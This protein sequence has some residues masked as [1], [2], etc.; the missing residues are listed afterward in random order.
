VSKGTCYIT[1]VNVV[2]PHGERRPHIA[3]VKLR[4]G[5]IET[6]EQVIRFLD[7]GWKYYTDPPGGTPQARVVAVSCSS[8]TYGD[9]ITTEPDYTDEN[10]LLDLPRF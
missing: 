2:H 7:L 9:Y 8:C 5:D 4:N 10:N 6:K 3:K 1:E